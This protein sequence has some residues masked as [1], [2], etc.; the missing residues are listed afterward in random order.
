MSIMNFD[1]R[2][3]GTVVEE[4]GGSENRPANKTFWLKDQFEGREVSVAEAMSLL[5]GVV[6][7]ELT[8]FETGLLLSRLYGG[9][10]TTIDIVSTMINGSIPSNYLRFLKSMKRVIIG[11]AIRRRGNQDRFNYGDVISTEGFSDPDGNLIGQL[12][13]TRKEEPGLETPL[14]DPIDFVGGALADIV[15][16]G[17]RMAIELAEEQV[18][19]YLAKEAG[20]GAMAGPRDAVGAF[21][22]AGEVEPR[23]A[24][25]ASKEWTATVK[26]RM[27]AL[28]IPKKY[29]GIRGIPGESGEAFTAEGTT[30]GGNVRGKGISV[31]GSVLEDWAGFPEW[32]KAAVI[33]RIDAVIAHEWM[34]FNELTHWESVELGVETNLPV[35]PKAKEL[36]GV[37]QKKGLGWKAALR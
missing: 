16:R 11:Y 2:S 34:E 25:A 37:M 17:A 20:V 23:V 1:L 14:L 6:N 7:R 22:R 8:S 31:H 24:A 26:G 10:S 28:N 19:R 5:Q 9:G 32:N 29:R 18:S 35:S 27:E 3:E 12:T 13:V 21:W 15:R 33:D 4:Y 36:L 30:R